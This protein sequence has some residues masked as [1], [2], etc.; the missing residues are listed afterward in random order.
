MLWVNA[1]IW[2]CRHIISELTKETG[3]FLPHVHQHPI[4]Y[5]SSVA[6][7]Y[8]DLC[9]TR[10]VTGA[11]RCKLCDFD[12]CEK[13]AVRKDAAE[14]GENV[15]RSDAGVVKEESVSGTDYLK[16]AIQLAGPQWQLVSV[17]FVLLTAYCGTQIVLPHFQGSIIDNVVRVDE[18]SFLDNI[19]LYLGVMAVQGA[20]SAMYSACFAQVSR[21]LVFYVR[22]TLFAQILRQVH[23]TRTPLLFLRPCS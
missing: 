3:L 13:C 23:L 22:N 11:W 8:C 1:E 5:E 7:H 15:L 9:S 6:C 18:D 17:S 12:L 4:F 14:V 20:L 21:Q 2:A 19:K 16:R 10:I